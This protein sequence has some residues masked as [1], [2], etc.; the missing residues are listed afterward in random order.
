MLDELP[1]SIQQNFAA[2]GGLSVMWAAAEFALDLIIRTVHEKHGGSAIEPE[3]PISF[4]RKP[5]YL[6]K[7]FGA[8]PDLAPHKP[9]LEELLREA[10]EIAEQRKWCMHGVI[11]SDLGAPLILIRKLIPGPD[12]REDQREFTQQKIDILSQRAGALSL[13]LALFGLQTVGIMPKKEA[14]KIISEFLGRFGASLPA[15]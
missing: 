6:R 7:A 5:R 12:Y 4:N 1:D 3:P 9:Y 10:T 8:S 15:D 11:A 14:D 13:N 2:I